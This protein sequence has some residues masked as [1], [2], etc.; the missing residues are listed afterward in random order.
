MTVPLS[1]FI[2]YQQQP[3]HQWG[4]PA[5]GASLP[6]GVVGVDEVVTT[7]TMGANIII[8]TENTTMISGPADLHRS[9]DSMETTTLEATME[10]VVAMVGAH[11]LY[12]APLVSGHQATQCPKAQ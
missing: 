12:A 5:A 1:G 2:N 3:R 6:A 10:E 8:L 4:S 7:I 9:A 11:V